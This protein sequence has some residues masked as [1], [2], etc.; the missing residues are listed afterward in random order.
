[1]LTIRRLNYLSPQYGTPDPK[2]TLLS[3][4]THIFRSD[5]CPPRIFGP[6]RVSPTDLDTTKARYKQ[7]RVAWAHVEGKG[8]RIDD[9][10]LKVAHEVSTC[11]AVLV[12]RVNDSTTAT[13][14]VIYAV[15]DLVFL[16]ACG[17]VDERR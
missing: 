1:M 9:A 6:L 15:A 5:L 13:T 8:R 17:D 11:P 10:K 3:H 7:E 4:V 2:S 14:L 12:R 16:V